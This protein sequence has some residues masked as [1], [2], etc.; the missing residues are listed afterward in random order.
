MRKP[1]LP[2]LN[3]EGLFIAR[4]WWGN[5]PCPSLKGGFIY[6]SGLVGKPPLPLKQGGLKQALLNKEGLQSFAGKA[7]TFQ[8]RDSNLVTKL[9]LFVKLSV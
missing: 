4:A 6:S 2:L 8:Y 7:E 3:K 9:M 1:P 5:L